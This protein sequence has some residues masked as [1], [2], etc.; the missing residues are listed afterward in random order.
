MT[1]NQPL[2]IAAAEQTAAML[3]YAPVAIYVSAADCQ[4]LLYV[5]QLAKELFFSAGGGAY[6]KMP[7]F[8]DAEEKIQHSEFLTRQYRYPVNQHIYQISFKTIDWAGRAAHIAY[9][10]DITNTGT[11]EYQ[12][13]ALIEELQTAFSGI[14][15]GFCV[16]RAV[17]RHIYPV[18][19]NPAF[20]T[21]LGYSEEHIRRIEQ[22]TEY[23]GVHPDDIALL[24]ER[25]AEAL[26]C[27]GVLQQTY[28]VWS[29]MK[30]EYQWIQ[31]AGAVKPQPD[32]SKLFYGIYSDVSEQRRLEREIISYNEKMQ[33]I[34]NAIPGGV[35]IYK[36]SD[37]FETVYFSDG[38]AELSGYTVEEY[39]KMV[40][41]DAVRLTYPE[42]TAM[43]AKKLH[44]AIKDNNVVDLEFRK[45]HRDGHIVWVHLQARPVGEEDGIPLLQCVF[46]NISTLK[47]TQSE[48]DHLVNS[49]P[50]GIASYRIEGGRFIPTYYS[51]GVLAI[52]GHTR[53]EFEELVREDAMNIIYRS[54]RERVAAAA[55]AAVE[56]GNVLDV[57]YRMRH[58]DGNLI[59]VNLNGRR[60][61]PMAGNMK[62]YAVFTGISSESQLFRSIVNETADGIY[63]IDRGN[64]DLLYANESKELFGNGPDKVGQKCYAS[65]FGKQGPCEACALKSRMVDGTGHL[66]KIDS[67]GRFYDT[68]VKETDWNGIP[69]YV[70]YVKDVTETVHSRREKE[71]LEQYFQTMVKNLPGGVAVVCCNKDG[72]MAPEFLSDGFAEMTGMTNQEA[73][74]L[75][76]KDAMKGVHPDD[77]Q[78]TIRH[79]EEF[80]DSGGTRS[81]LEYRLL[82]GDG[83][84][85]WVKNT[86][87][88]LMSEGGEKRLYASYHDMTA[89]R[90][91]QER[92]RQQYKDMILQHYLMPGPNA[93]I[94]GHCNITRN[95]ILEIIDHTDSNLLENFSDSREAFF[96]GIGNL[97]V[98]EAE[99][100]TFMDSYLN[101]PALE[102]YAKGEKEVL[103]NCFIKLPKDSV[104][105]YVQFKVN[106][107]EAPDTGDVTG[108]L[109]V[110]DMT[111]QVIS[112]RIMHRL[113]VVNCDLVVDVDLLQDHCALLSGKLEERDVTVGQAFH[114]D[115]ISY[116]LQEQV[117]PRD[118]ERVARMMD[119]AYMRTRLE[120]E[121]SYSLSFS[122]AE[123]GGNISAKK[124]TVSAI[125][126]RIGRICLA[127][128][129]ITDSVRE[130]QGLLNVV[131][132]T[133]ELLAMINVDTGRLTLHTRKT[134]LENLPP[135]TVDNYN[136]AVDRIAGSYGP[137]LSDAERAEIGIQV[138]LETMRSRLAESPSGYDF[139]LP[140]QG[141]DGLRYK[142]VNILWGDSD[143][144]TV[145]MVRAD[146]TDMLAEERQRKAELEDAL[147]QAEQA[148]QAKSDFLSSMSHDIRTPM[149]AI[150]GMTALASAHMDDRERLE[151]CLEK[152]SFSSRHLLSLIND[153]LDMS[154]I[155]QGKIALN[156][157]NLLLTE[158]VGQI[159]AMLTTQAEDAVL[160][161]T[162]EMK[163]IVHTNIYGDSLRINQILIN[164][165]GN[166]IKFT[167]EGGLVNLIVEEIPPK[168]EKALCAR[169]RFTIRDT[170]IG[171]AEEFLGHIFEP[172]TRSHSTEH[173]EGTGLGLS[174]TKGL[175]DLMGGEIAVVSKAR[176][177]TTFRVELEFELA[178]T[179]KRDTRELETDCPDIVKNK[180]LEG[181]YFLVAEDNAINS[182]ILCELLQM[183]GA[184]TVVKTDGAK[185]VQAFSEAVPGTYD[186][187][188]M[189]I[190]MPEMNGYEAA[191]AIRHLQRPDAGTIPII[192]MTANAFAED[193]QSAL[194]AG[195][196]AHL[197]KPIDIKKL[198]AVLEKYLNR[199]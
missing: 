7:W 35:A 127:R 3:D 155:E 182:E 31:L 47:E 136:G 199:T 106:L 21:I 23:L 58:K 74:Q 78:R 5:N 48:L 67:T 62:F 126:L 162:V 196:N 50:G 1:Y 100:K 22:R 49:I 146:V 158:L 197:A 157:G 89:E 170:G 27:D 183:Y 159:A 86:L 115:R 130:Q 195:M 190:Q 17:G 142:Q 153:I 145:C 194:E 160:K 15:C 144:K 54:D 108:V 87:S 73:W 191:R 85:V 33:D 147:L 84:Y 129:D 52:S 53:A 140:Y 18:F 107:V 38:V 75:Y 172:F 59:W 44:Q 102:A 128:S 188:L 65:L 43:V 133:F 10:T 37:I 124:L 32:G 97:V 114:S 13:R 2:S 118:R 122:V 185:A 14:P 42:D 96:T 83:S 51:D 88:M 81:E 98:D 93:L 69:A 166:A 68:S 141:Q 111:E 55:K 109:T 57:A 137:Q 9:V 104:G 4:E 64:H 41:C 198:L 105:R 77:R 186:A 139:V 116:M 121:G 175:V 80:I 71:R 189:D 187:V 26:K 135:Y 152:I 165:I 20:Y 99:R 103:Q 72:S 28:R 143:H 184:D 177:G 132:Y 125:D 176:K 36:V 150:M 151:D 174:I 112:E 8:I 181:G 61:G 134:V 110:T 70:L 138:C 120:R 171:M 154:K 94:L 193:I 95:H 101:V 29:D 163:N 148:N 30:E 180:V 179:N 117:V 40:K 131:A 56:S 63:V 161:F 113:S 24:R 34:I 149:N 164:I 76:E 91:E 39:Q 178:Q 46:H 167:P 82:K 90:E 192:A 11:E 19:H 92:I 119:P 169:Y 16:Y 6:C 156:C 168:E 66:M 79:M 25:V 45:L 123:E 12:T 60:M 173:V